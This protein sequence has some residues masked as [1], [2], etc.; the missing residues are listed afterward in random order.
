MTGVSD[1]DDLHLS[2]RADKSHA[3]LL[4]QPSPRALEEVTRIIEGMGARIMEVIP[5]PKNWMLLKLDVTDMREVVLRLT[6]NGFLNIKG[7]NALELTKK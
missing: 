3:Q 6:E 2:V 7:I 1:S 4:I 5:L